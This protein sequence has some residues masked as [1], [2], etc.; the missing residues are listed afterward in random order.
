MHVLM[1]VGARIAF[2]V[3]L[4]GFLNTASDIQ[5]TIAFLGLFSGFILLGLA[6]VLSR[7][8]PGNRNQ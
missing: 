1:F 5:L 2:L 6:A 4:L 8:P 3:S 7:I